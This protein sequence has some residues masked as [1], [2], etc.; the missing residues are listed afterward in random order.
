MND[1]RK[2]CNCASIIRM[3]NFVAIKGVPLFLL[4]LA[5]Q[6]KHIWGEDEILL[7]KV[8]RNFTHSNLL[9]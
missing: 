7:D 4:S 2:E 6:E 8:S 5:I 3:N 9:I 1:C